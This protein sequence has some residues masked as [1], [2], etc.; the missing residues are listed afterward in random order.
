MSEDK[1]DSRQ[2]RDVTLRLKVLDQQGQFFGDPVDIEIKHRTLAGEPRRN[3]KNIASSGEIQIAGLRRFPQSDYTVTI[4]PSSKFAPESQFVTIPASG[5]AELT[6][7]LDKEA[8]GNGKPPGEDLTLR[9]KILNP[10]GAFF[11]DPVDIDIKHRTI[12][13]EPRRELRSV[14]ATAEIPVKGLRRPP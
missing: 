14:A 10:Q 2:E 4:T 6:F 11:R 3:L 13:S 5:S 7:E 12:E 1:K 9:L 8:G